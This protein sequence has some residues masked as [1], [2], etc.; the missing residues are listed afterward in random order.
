MT[1]SEKAAPSWEEVMRRERFFND[2]YKRFLTEFPEQFVA[3]DPTT[4]AVVAANPDLAD[5]VADLRQRGLT[6]WD[7]AIELISEQSRHLIL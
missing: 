5:L 6:V 3:I 1:T 7:V 4:G 2:N